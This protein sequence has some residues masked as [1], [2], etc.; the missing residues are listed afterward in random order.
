VSYI[1]LST[2]SG[3]KIIS[4]KSGRANVKIGE[5]VSISFDAANALYFDPESGLRCYSV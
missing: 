1:Y 3:E 4:E 5:S 2:Q